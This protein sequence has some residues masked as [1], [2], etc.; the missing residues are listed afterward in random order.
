MTAAA[1]GGRPRAL[2]VIEA[3]ALAAAVRLGL[4]CCSLRRVASALAAI[5][6][7]RRQPIEPLPLCLAAARAAASRLA[8][9]TC[10]FESL[11]AFGL[12]ARRG[13]GVE[14]HLG[15]RRGEAFESHA[16]VTAGGRPCEPEPPPGYTEMWRVAAGSTPR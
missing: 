15:A 6:A 1:V 2:T 9:P 16:W 3:H 4:R 8:H 10:L 14:L 11:V 13:Y 5:P 7:S 12:L